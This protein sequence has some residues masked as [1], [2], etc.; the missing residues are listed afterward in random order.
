MATDWNYRQLAA[1]FIA[2]ALFVWAGCGAAVSSNRWTPTALLLDPGALVGIALAFGITISVLAYSIG[3]ISGGHINPAVTLSFMLLRLQSITAGLLYMVA[4]CLGAIFGA[5]ILWGCNASLTANCD[6]ITA[7]GLEAQISGVCGASELPNGE[8]YGPAFGLG[9][10]TVDIRVSS[11]CAF[12]IELMGTYLLVFTV[13][14][15]AVH[16]KSTGGNAVPI[17]I[18]WAVLVAHLILIPYTGCGINPARSLG[19]MVVDSMGGLNYWQ[20]GWWVFYTAPF[21]GSILATATYK[22]IF[23]EEEEDD[24]GKAKKD[25]DVA[26][27]DD[28]KDVE[29]Q[30]PRIYD[31]DAKNTGEEAVTDDAVPHAYE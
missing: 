9:V 21:V 26:G 27:G 29:G 12:L 17:A 19:P 25:D 14:Q 16:T 22:F 8:G 5:L 1:E 11:G 6:T 4:Q 31:E 24:A 28:D 20:R 30:V 7:A 2:T 18:G 23:A 13:L 3:H 10:N 15:A